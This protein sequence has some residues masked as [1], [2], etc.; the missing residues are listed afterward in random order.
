MPDIVVHLPDKSLAG[1]NQS[2][3]SHGP[4]DVKRYNELTELFKNDKISLVFVTAFES[5]KAMHKY[6]TEIAWETEVW[7]ARNA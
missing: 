6:L 3:T 7:V 1:S 2:V 4:V 5:R